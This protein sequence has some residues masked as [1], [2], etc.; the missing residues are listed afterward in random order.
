MRLK[1]LICALLLVCMAAVALPEWLP[2]ALAA[3]PY[4]IT[5]DLTN[6]IVTV[7]DSNNLTESGI[8]RQMICS[9]G[10]PGM[11]TPKGTFTLPKKSRA[12][13]RTEWYYFA[14]SHCY[15]KWATR[16]KGG[17]LFH[18]ILYNSKKG[19]PTAASVN[20]LGTKASH[21]CVRLKVEDAK[22]IA[23]NC[24]AGTKVKI[25][26]GKKNKALRKLMLIAYMKGFDDD[27]DNDN[28]GGNDTPAPLS[29]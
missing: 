13:E 7:Y 11:G 24:P 16:I 3:S 4:Y 27:G 1:R 28:G 15:A 22:W 8:V 9:S 23:M 6:Q 17:I 21:G 5:V 20:A 12:S 19:N 2:S 26:D 25:L 29:A 14:S 18:S 10:R